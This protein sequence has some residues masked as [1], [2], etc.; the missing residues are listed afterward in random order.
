[1]ETRADSV[2]MTIAK[3]VVFLLLALIVIKLAEFLLTIIGWLIAV[4]V[5]I[6]IFAVLAWG[7]YYVLFARKVRL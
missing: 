4:A 7:I 3:V 2:G 1:M 5:S 6:T